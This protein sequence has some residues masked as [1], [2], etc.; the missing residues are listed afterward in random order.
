MKQTKTTGGLNLVV[1][2][3][4][5]SLNSDR[6]KDTKNILLND[7]FF[8][9][10]ITEQQPLSNLDRILKTQAM[11]KATKETEITFSDPI[12]WQNE[13]AVIFPNTI[14]VIQGQNGSHKSRL[15]E[16]M[17][18]ALLKIDNCYNELLGFKA[19]EYIRYALCHVDTERNL[20]EQLP[21]ALQSIQVKAGYSIIDHPTNFDYISLLEIPRKER[22]TVLNEY[23]DYVREKFNM[24]IFIVLDVTTDCIC[25]FNDPKDSME[26]ID[27]MNM[28]INQ[29]DVTFLCIVHENPGQQKAR[30]HLGTELLNK[31]STGIQ[32]G[33]EKDASNEDTDIIKV[34]YI[35]C[36]STKR[37]DPFYIKYSDEAKSLILADAS[38]VSEIV[39]NRKHKANETDIIEF[40]ETYLSEGEM[41]NSDLLDKLCKDFKAS[42]KTISG[43][44]KKIIE[45]D[46]EIWCNNVQCKLIKESKGKEIIFKLEPVTINTTTYHD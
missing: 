27:L 25:N 21:Y 22:F 19:N 31:A 14:N 12:M 13:K 24:H 5:N 40:L 6:N 45:G 23:L 39:N 46:F 41:L 1:E 16:M 3:P 8:T 9:E 29:Y 15:A 28:A 42:A 7:E 4:E 18:S 44:L 35:K 37:H 38:D 43:R 10:I 33:F 36:R 20:K 2:T 32:V 30:G 34:K 11:L 26:L 17:C